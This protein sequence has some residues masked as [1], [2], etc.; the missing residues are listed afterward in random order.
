MHVPLFIQVDIFEHAVHNNHSDGQQDQEHHHRTEIDTPGHRKLPPNWTQHGLCNPVDRLNDRI[1]W[2]S[3]PR[4]NNSRKEQNQIQ[5]D[6]RV[7]DI[8][9]CPEYIQ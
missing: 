8:S 3:D 5:R 7:Q 2:Q 1:V 9:E 4:K 6:D